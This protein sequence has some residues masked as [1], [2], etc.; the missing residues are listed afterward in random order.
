[1]NGVKNIINNHY[2][3]TKN[4]RAKYLLDVIKE[5][6]DVI[7]IEGTNSDLDKLKEIVKFK[8]DYTKDTLSILRELSTV[9]KLAFDLEFEI[10]ERRV[11]NERFNS[12]IV[13]VDLNDYL[14]EEPKL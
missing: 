14:G 8:I 5:V 2:V 12:S 1:M 7:R 10:T 4:V 3:E 13:R 6:A 11:A 9:I